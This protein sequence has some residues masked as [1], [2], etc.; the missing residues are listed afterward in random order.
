MIQ[1]ETSF[2]VAIPEPSDE[3]VEEC[4]PDEASPDVSDSIESPKKK[5]RG[6]GL[7]WIDDNENYA[8]VHAVVINAA[9][10]NFGKYSS[11]RTEHRYLSKSIGCN[12]IMKTEFETMCHVFMNTMMVRFKRSAPVILLDIV[13]TYMS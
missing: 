12:N 6:K 8:T 7:N 9:S 10:M 13:A 3:I 4:N 1:R 2:I 5:S 11:T